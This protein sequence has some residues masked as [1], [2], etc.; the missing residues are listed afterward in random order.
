MKVDLKRRN[1]KLHWLFYSF[2]SFI[3]LFTLV[4]ASGCTSQSKPTDG[5]LQVVTTIYPVY[6]LAKVIGGDK[7]DVTMLVA[8]GVE[9][10]DWEPTVSNLK[11]IGKAQVF[12]YNGAGM[13]PVQ[14]LLTKDVLRQALP[15]DLSKSV[16]V[17]PM[18]EEEVNLEADDRHTAA[19]HTDNHEAEHV[20]MDDPHIW[21]DPLNVE[22]EVDAVVAAFSKEDPAN[23]AY[24]AENGRKYKEQLQA[25]NQAYVDWAK[26]VKDKNLVVTHE[27][28]GYL[29]AQYGF[30]QVGIMGIS[31]DTEPTPDKMARI[32]SFI[33]KNHVKAI[34]SEALVSPKLADAI[35]KETGIHVYQLNTVE[36]LSKEDMAQGDTYL[37]LM[38]Q[39]LKILQ[40]ALH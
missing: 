18:E 5:K 33:K 22:K 2:L 28:F 24:Y 15:V 13:E 14:K 6:D 39:N 21:L 10:H 34:F 20:H 32:V 4:L 12:L 3:F 19:N 17:R 29:A 7:A 9:P 16:V 26:T 38:R 25:L 8:P 37:T 1:S 31:P 35:A 36:A 30:K 11:A 23:A 40:E 27:A